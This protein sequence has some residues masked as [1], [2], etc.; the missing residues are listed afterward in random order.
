M[1]PPLPRLSD[2]DVSP[3]NG[4]LPDEIPL[5]VLPD[6]YYSP[7]ETIAR[8]FQSLI[9]AKRLRRV[10]DSMP[11]LNTELLLT[12]AEW[13]RAYSLL[14]FIAHGYIWGGDSPADV[15]GRQPEHRN[16]NQGYRIANS[17]IRSSRLRYQS[18]S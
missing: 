4:F 2:Y 9:L 11:V 10:V 8:N 3:H 16:A 18:H 17:T 5:D 1:L 12:E 7:W 6:S 14:G 15:G 13:R